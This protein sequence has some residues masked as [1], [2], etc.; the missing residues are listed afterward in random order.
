MSGTEILFLIVT[1]FI[2][3]FVIFI[4]IAVFAAVKSLSQVTQTLASLQKQIDSLENAPRELIDNAN[5]LSDDVRI[6]IDCLS[7]LF[8]TVSNVG[9]SLEYRT[10][11]MRESQ[12]KKYIREQLDDEE[13]DSKTNGVAQGIEWVLTG[14]SLWENYKKRR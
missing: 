10:S 8:R 7:P 6:K 4:G 12:R 9:E 2:G 1:I 13:E 11:K 14:L 5:A 3:L